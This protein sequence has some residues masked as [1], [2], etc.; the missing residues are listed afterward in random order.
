MSTRIKRSRWQA[1]NKKPCANHWRLLPGIILLVIDNI[2]E[3]FEVELSLFRLLVVD[4]SSDSDEKPLS[5]LAREGPR[6]RMAITAP[7]LRC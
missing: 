3:L 7:L 2:M 5:V 4:A 1:I 6:S